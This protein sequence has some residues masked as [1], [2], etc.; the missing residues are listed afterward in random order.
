MFLS[1]AHFRKVYP[2]LGLS[3]GCHTYCWQKI[4]CRFWKKALKSIIEYF[5]SIISSF[6]NWN[7]WMIHKNLKLAGR[8]W[9]GL[10]TKWC[11]SGTAGHFCTKVHAGCVAVCVRPRKTHLRKATIMLLLPELHGV[12]LADYLCVS[13]TGKT[14]PLQETEEDIYIFFRPMTVSGV[15]LRTGYNQ[16][17]CLVRWHALR[18][19]A[20]SDAFCVLLFLCVF[21]F[22]EK[23]SA[24]SVF[25][26]LNLAF[27]T[28]SRPPRVCQTWLTRYGAFVVYNGKSQA[29][30]KLQ[31]M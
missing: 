27:V 31:L 9:W 17:E 10:F 25:A 5:S 3:L 29:R 8:L 18:L 28:A 2:R 21:F 20:A 11:W 23:G 15:G 13:R 1:Y 22:T 16:A 4:F 19:S 26:V 6:S 7:E 30:W 14:K 24:P 12:I